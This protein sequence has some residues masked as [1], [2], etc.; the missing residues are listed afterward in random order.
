MKFSLAILIF[1]FS[2]V[3][4]AQ[5]YNAIL[6]PDSM[7]K[8]ADVVKRYEEYVLTIKSPA[9]YTLYEKHV[10]TI[11]N[12][13]AS[14]YGVYTTNYDKFCSINSVEGKLFNKMGGEIKHTKKKD[15]KDNSAYDGFSLL[16]DSRYKENE[17]Y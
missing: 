7:R 5:E 1:S 9:K 3:V 15:W 17:F 13:A 6:I 10:Y 2:F 4:K 12:E 16:S 11:L 8:G 14:H